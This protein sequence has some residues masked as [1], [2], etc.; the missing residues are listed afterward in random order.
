MRRRTVIALVA[1]LSSGVAAHGQEKPVSFTNDVMPFLLKAGCASGTCHAKPEGQNNFKLSVFAFDPKHDYNEIVRDD[2][3]RRLFLAAPEESLLLKK[4]TGAIPHEG[5]T[6]IDP[7]SEAYRTIL[8]WI[9]Q[10]VPFKQEGEPKLAGVSVEPRGKIYAKLAAQQLKV[11]A[12]YSD[13]SVRDVTR[14]SLYTSNDKEVAVVDEQGLVKVG[15]L[16]GE[17]V[18]VASYMGLVDVARI[19]VP[20]DKKLP[21]DLYAKLPVNNEIDRLVWARL[22]K[23]GIA[24]SAGCTDEEFL[25]RA[26]LDSIGVLPSAGQAKEFI[27]STDPKKREKLVDQ[28]LQHPNYPDHWA[29]KWGDLIRPNPSRVG[30]KPVFLLDA[31]L[32]DAFRRNMPYDEMVRT[33]LTAQGSTHEY[34][35]VALFRDKREPADASAFVSQIFLGVRMDC[36]RCHHHPSEKW[37]QED[38]Y[39]LAACFGQM[40][41]KGQGI[42]API[43]GEP[44]F[45]WY[46]PGGKVEH[47]VTEAVMTPKAPDGPEMPY[48]DGQDPRARLVDWM[49][50]SD[51]PFFA[52]AITNRIWGE[53]FGRGIVEPV[54]D[55]RASNPPT[56]E[57]LIEWLA[58]DFVAHGHDLKHLMRTIMLSHVYQLSS[59]P[60]EHNI[61]DTKNFSRSYR[62]RLTAEVLLDAV[63]DVTGVKDGY[64]GLPKGSRAVQTWNHKLD[65]DFMDAFGRPN[66]SQECPCE[67]DRKPSVVQ[68]LHLMNSNSLQEKLSS[69]DGRAAKLAKSSLAEPGIVRELYLATF[70]RLPQAGELQTALRF[71]NAPG[72]TKATATQD[73]AWALINSAEFV[74]N[75]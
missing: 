22:K 66:A 13:G 23:L 67:R 8:T 26:S 14:L 73:L 52:K 31:W 65:S 21:D 20:A 47:P 9:R 44:E 34:G 39:Q 28:L 41:R 18:V 40:K 51:N 71:F 74:F 75:H 4:A 19:T 7:G 17:G 11:T 30:V 6:R 68:A 62:R 43:S 5:G 3:G 70:N 12:R 1:A 32:R 10:G 56:N 15:A 50:G 48:I 58:K 27:A 29:I 25:R 57:E 72:A 45:I 33:L 55:F 42:S 37:T 16:N 63:C 53:F 54:D 61:A 59:L 24:P 38:Y 60:D 2:R 46:A 64:S 35:P 69:D 36:A 49:G